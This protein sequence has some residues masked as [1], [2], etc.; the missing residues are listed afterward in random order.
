MCYI[1]PGQTGACDRY[2]NDRG[3]IVRCDPVTILSRTLEQGGRVVPFAEP[4][5]DGEIIRPADA[6]V[7]VARARDWSQEPVN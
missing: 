3:R 2:A 7:K 1:A 4:S 6:F 5:W